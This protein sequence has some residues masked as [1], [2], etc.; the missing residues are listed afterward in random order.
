M[1][2]ITDTDRVLHV[3]VDRAGRT[4]RVLERED[5]TLCVY[6]SEAGDPP[7]TKRIVWDTS[8]IWTDP[9]RVLLARAERAE[10]RARV[11]QRACEDALAIAENKRPGT[12]DDVMLDM[13]DALKEA[14]HG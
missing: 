3:A 4:W 6:Y 11:L 1:D 5:G 10:A 7:E 9:P 13:R 14:K 12:W 8:D 2:V